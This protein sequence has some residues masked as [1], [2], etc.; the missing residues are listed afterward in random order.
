MSG[1]QDLRAE[2]VRLGSVLSEVVESLRHPPTH[3]S[4]PVGRLGGP[5]SP[6]DDLESP[7]LASKDI[8]WKKERNRHE[9][10]FVHRLLCSDDMSDT[11]YMAFVGRRFSIVYS[12]VQGHTGSLWPF[13]ARGGRSCWGVR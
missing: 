4:A 8:S 10:E 6:A 12:R 1:I 9:Y 3:V 2:V 7:I 11:D 13:H 5:R